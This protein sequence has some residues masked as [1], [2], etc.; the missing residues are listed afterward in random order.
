MKEQ[1]G[2]GF[3]YLAVTGLTL[4]V[5]FT[6]MFINNYF[7]W[8]TLKRQKA[9]QKAYEAR[10]K[11]L[12]KQLSIEKAERKEEKER[13]K[14]LRNNDK[15]K[16]FQELEFNIGQSEENGPSAESLAG[17]SD[18]DQLAI[19]QAHKEKIDK[20][21]KKALGKAMRGN[22]QFARKT[23]GL[24][25]MLQG[26]LP[27]NQISEAESIDEAYKTVRQ[28]IESVRSMADLDN[29]VELFELAEGVKPSADDEKSMIEKVLK[30][31]DKIDV[32]DPE[33]H[34][35]EDETKIVEE[36]SIMDRARYK[37]I[38]DSIS[39]LDQMT[40]QME[41]QNA[42]TY[43][44]GE[45]LCFLSALNDKF[46]RVVSMKSIKNARQALKSSLI[47]ESSSDLEFAIMIQAIDEELKELKEEQ[48][49]ILKDNQLGKYEVKKQEKVSDEQPIEDEEAK[50]MFKAIA[51]L[52]LDLNEH[53]LKPDAT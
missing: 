8:R 1:Y 34:Y 17:K 45:A 7:K 52:K 41:N 47:D 16:F 21:I 22:R 39:Y 9:S 44:T 29:E 24:A 50:E 53:D 6:W 18:V 33:E 48:D 20:E 26:Q 49:T 37:Q 35:P 38:L 51:N 36:L 4:A 40:K 14:I 31:V 5:N 11:A 3:S 46:Q 32:M 28:R 43:S 27:L 2:I 42:M 10:F 15:L 25:A 23:T 13:Q 30:N 19:M 12:V